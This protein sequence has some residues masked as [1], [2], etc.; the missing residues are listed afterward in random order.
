MRW[1]RRDFVQAAAGALASGSLPGCAS[2]AV[3]PVSAPDGVIRLPLR[4]HPRLTQPGGYLKLRPD[5]ASTPVYVL[6]VADG[7]VAVSPI[8]MHL[9]C[10]VDVQGAR[11]VCPCHGSTYD[12]EGNVLRGPTL[13]PLRR[14]AT[15]LTGEGELL[16][17]LDGAP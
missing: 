17:R 8:C 9:G 6:A 2:V 7:Y 12:R 1:S 3:T 4:A 11:L 15:T 16:I 14:Y 5:G 10:T 13:K